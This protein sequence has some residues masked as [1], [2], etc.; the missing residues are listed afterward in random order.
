MGIG[1]IGVE[2]VD[3]AKERVQHRVSVGGHGIPEEDIERRYL[4]TFEN[5]NKI[6][7]ECDRVLFYDNS[8]EF[9]RFAIMEK[10]NII[11]LVDNIPKWF[12][13]VKR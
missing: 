2:T 12:N 7:P 6:I 4:E 1:I 9:E 13:K 11:P 10:G 5:L 8:K 3:I